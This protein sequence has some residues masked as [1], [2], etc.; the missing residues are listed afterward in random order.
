MSKV[1]SSRI[2]SWRWK[3]PRKGKAASRKAWVRMIARNNLWVE[4]TNRPFVG[5]CATALWNESRG[6]RF[7]REPDVRWEFPNV[8]KKA[9]TAAGAGD[10]HLAAVETA[11]FAGLMPLVEHCAVIR[12][13]DGDSRLNG[14]IR[15]GCLGAAWTLDVKDPDS[16]MSF[17]V[18]DS[19]LD[20]VWEAAALLL[21]CDS[22][23]FSADPYLK[24]KP[25]GKRS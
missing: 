24:R 12:Y 13:D 23:P 9:A 19:S 21:A 22:A 17:R 18:V 8:K 20:K 7:L 14:W 10:R 25:P 16:E 4:L 11:I 6:T 1:S 3:P 2:T 15:M 5:I